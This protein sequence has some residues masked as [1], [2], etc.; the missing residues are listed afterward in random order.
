MGS[1][2][3]QFCYRA[4]KWVSESGV[5]VFRPIKVK[6]LLIVDLYYDS[7]PGS[8]VN[9]RPMAF[10]RLVTSGRAFIVRVK[11]GQATTGGS[12]NRFVSCLK[13]FCTHAKRFPKFRIGSESFSVDLLVVHNFGNGPRLPG[14]IFRLT[15]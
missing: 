11:P 1:C 4:L 6:F 3:K 10:G 15:A 5:L 14:Q 12:P 13:T 9:S 2:F 7:E 8:F